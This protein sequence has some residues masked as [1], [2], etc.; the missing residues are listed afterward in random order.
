MNNHVPE[1]S[2][3]LSQDITI[4]LSRLRDGDQ[5]AEAELAPLIYRQLRSIA[6]RQF[7]GSDNRQFDATEIA[8]EAY[9]RMLG[10]IEVEWR[11]RA[12]FFATAAT[13]IRRLLIDEARRR[14]AKKRGG[15][16]LQVTLAGIHDQFDGGDSD[17]LIDLHEALDALEELEPRRAKLV[18]LRFFSGLTQDEAADV[19]AVSRRTAAADWALA[20]A[21]LF[22]RLSSGASS[23]ETP[24]QDS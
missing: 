15:D 22:R 2:P 24:S 6:Q 12:H 7:N 3:V 8:H 13:I 16:A 1:V 20:K 19:L 10:E 4:L 17:Q 14:Q 11:D 5:T 23:N 18:E 21:W 9:L